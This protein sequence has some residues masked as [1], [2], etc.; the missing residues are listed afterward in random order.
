MTTT[1]TPKD[2]DFAAM[3]EKKAH[4][5]PQ[6]LQ[7]APEVGDLTAGQL[8]ELAELAEAPE[9]SDEDLARQALEHPGGDGDASTPE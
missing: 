7:E 3:L 8:A 5:A 2:G 1:N 4:P 6:T 9:L